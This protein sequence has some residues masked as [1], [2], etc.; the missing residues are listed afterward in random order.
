M[1]LLMTLILGFNMFNSDK[2]NAEVTKIVKIPACSPV[3]VGRMSATEGKFQAMTGTLR[4]RIV[5][6]GHLTSSVMLLDRTLH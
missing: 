2:E 3:S 6:P 1:C 4:R 5:S